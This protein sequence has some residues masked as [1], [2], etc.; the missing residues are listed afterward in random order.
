[1]SLSVSAI[2]PTWNVGGTITATLTALKRQTAPPLEIIVV[3]SGSGDD[4]VQR[5]GAAGA[6]VM[7]LPV[8]DHGATRTAAARQARGDIVVF[9]TQDARIC[10]NDILEEILTPFSTDPEI[11]AVFGR[12]IPCKD[13]N[14]FAQ[15]LRGFNYPESSYV[16]IYDDRDRLGVKTIFFS[17]AFGAYRRDALGK[18]G[19]FKAG[20]IFGE[21]M[22]AAAALLKMG[23]KIAYSAS[24]QVT[25]SHNYSL[26]REFSRYFDMGVM[27]RREPWLLDEFGSPEGEGVKY[28]GSVIK[29]AAGAGKWRLLPETLTR[30]AAKYCG[31]LAGRHHGLLPANLCAALS[32]NPAWWRRGCGKT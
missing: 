15:H 8:F 22:L 30:I 16:R 20:L 25:H 4:T 19:W 12:Q 2:I 14:F 23:F 18:A 28:V 13:A 3:D 31:Y 21:D 6:L 1:M 27:H 24:A 11:A 32:M 7:T 17:N 5:A 29:A 9:F 10:R 26:M